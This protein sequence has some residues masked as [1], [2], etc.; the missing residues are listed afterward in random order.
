MERLYGAPLT[1]LDAVK[2]TTSRNPEQVLIN[3]LNVWSGSVIACRT[4][5]ADVHAG[6]LNILN[7][8]L[9]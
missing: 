1:D 6:N 5:H 7:I 3:A 4:F 2:R 8:D 9:I